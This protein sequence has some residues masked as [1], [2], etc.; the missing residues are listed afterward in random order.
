M[1]YCDQCLTAWRKH[2]CNTCTRYGCEKRVHFSNKEITDECG[3][4][5]TR[6]NWQPF[7]PY[8]KYCKGCGKEL[9]KPKRLHGVQAKLEV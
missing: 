2:Q 8:S 9:Y 3:G 1:T 7:L 5:V 4:Y 6:A